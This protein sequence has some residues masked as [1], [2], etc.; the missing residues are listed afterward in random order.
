[1]AKRKMKQL[2]LAVGTVLG[3]LSLMPSAQAVNLATDGLGQVLI[4]P[5]Y[6]TRG[7][8]TTL[9]NITNTSNLVVAAKVRFHEAYNSRDVLDFTVVLSPHDV[10]TAWVE[11]GPNNV[12]RVRT[13]DTTCT[14]PAI[15]PEGQSFEGGLVSYTGAAADGGPDTTDRMREGYVKVLMNGAD[16]TFTSP[17]ALSYNAVHVNG[18]PRNCGIIRQAFG[19]PGG[20]AALRG[21]FPLYNAAINPLKG[22]FNLV[23]GPRGLTAG[24]NA[25]ALAD[26]YR[27]DLAPNYCNRTLNDFSCYVPGPEGLPATTYST[28]YMITLQLPPEKTG[29]FNTSFHEPNL[30]AANTQGRVLSA[31]GTVGTSAAES[32][33][34]GANAVNYVIRRSVVHNQWTRK[35]DAASSWGTATDWVVTFPTKRYYVDFPPPPTNPDAGNEFQGRTRVF[36]GGRAGLPEAFPAPYFVERFNGSSCIPVRSQIFDRE[37]FLI[38]DGPVFSPAPKGSQLCYEANVLS[39]NGDSILSS[40]SPIASNIAA[41]PGDNGW[42]SLDLRGNRSVV[43]FSI[44]TRDTGNRGLNEAFLVDHAYDSGR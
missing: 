34:T 2:A 9:F 13:N 8:W 42:L 28:N 44:T 29:N 14:V 3:S 40:V 36:G 5:Y 1:M 10:W 11:N 19:L 12:P 7:D 32:P 23:N 20:I 15:P 27:A 39:F 37:E 25:V 16:N 41:L 18:V 24:G 38:D 31:Q 43:G 22:S 35:T 4:F 33:P 30:N 6:T 17:L 21:A 26:F